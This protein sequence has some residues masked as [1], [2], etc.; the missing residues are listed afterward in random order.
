MG[1]SNEEKA[2]VK[3]ESDLDIRVY[4]INKKYVYSY[5]FRSQSMFLILYALN[6]ENLVVIINVLFF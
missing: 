3:D 1:I 6:I 4:I 2:S 5:T